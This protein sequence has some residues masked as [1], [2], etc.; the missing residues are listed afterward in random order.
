M[1]HLTPNILLDV[2]SGEARG[3]LPQPEIT[4]IVTDSRSVVP[5][6]LFAAIPGSKVD[7]A[8]ENHDAAL[9]FSESGIR[10]TAEKR[11]E[12]IENQEDMQWKNSA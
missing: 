4:A 3:E 11:S 1:R 2:T 10:M 6:C 7:R 8:D 12:K 9:T 5:G